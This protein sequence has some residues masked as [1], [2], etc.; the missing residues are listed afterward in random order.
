MWPR[1]REHAPEAVL[2]II[3]KD[4][5]GA[6]SRDASSA[7][8]IEVTGFVPDPTH[9]LSETAAFVVPL[10][11]GGGM[12][13]K[14]LDAWSHG[15]PVISTTV[16]AEGLAVR[17]GENLLLADTPEAFVRSVVRV[18]RDPALAARLAEGGRRTVEAHYN[19]RRVY[20]AWDDAYAQALAMRTS[21]TA[22]RADEVDPT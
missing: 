13:V 18:L 1:I 6:L 5:P 21:R 2:T 4:P 10:Q 12:R 22:R 20:A 8:G 19:W 11:S 16:G 9:Y 15:L 7:S 3:G 17:D 14:I